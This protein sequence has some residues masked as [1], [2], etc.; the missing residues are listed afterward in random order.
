MRSLSEQEFK[1]YVIKKAKE[2]IFET[3]DSLKDP[4]NESVEDS[5]TP[6]SVKQFVSELKKTT[7]SLS[8]QDPMMNE[9]KAVETKDVEEEEPTRHFHVGSYENSGIELK[10][11]LMETMNNYNRQKSL[12]HGKDKTNEA[13]ERLVDY[14]KFTEDK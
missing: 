10:E 8:F 13:W 14:K 4:I 5:I 7:A 11:T 3:T 9:S 1:E 2:Y 12:T 6:S